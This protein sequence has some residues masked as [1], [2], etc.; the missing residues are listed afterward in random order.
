MP[1]T[2]L[3]PATGI[4]D[5]EKLPP[6]SFLTRAQMVPILNVSVPTLKRWASE[7]KGPKVT[8]LENRVVRYRVS[9]VLHWM[10]A[11]DA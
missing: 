3:T 9:D 1:Q 5:I 6:S 2:C 7:G 8:H 10:G 4:A 11:E